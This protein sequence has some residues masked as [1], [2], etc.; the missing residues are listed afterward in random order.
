MNRLFNYLSQRL[1]LNIRLGF[2]DILVL[3]ASYNLLSIQ[4]KSIAEDPGT[5]W[6]IKTGLFILENHSIPSF[7][8][9]LSITRPWVSDQWLGDLIIATIYSLGNWQLL[10]TFFSIVFITTFFIIIR[11]N[12]TSGTRFAIITL[13][14]VVVAFKISQI[15]FLI[16]P[17]A[18]SFTFFTILTLIV[19]SISQKIGKN[20]SLNKYYWK[21]PLLFL[22]W[23][24]I[25]PSFILGLIIVGI[26]PF[27]CLLSPEIKL[28]L[29]LKLWLLFL[30]CTFCT[31]INPFGFALHHSILVLGQS[32][33]FMKLH[34]EWQSPDF[35]NIEGR[36]IEMVGLIIIFSA[37]IIKLPKNYRTFFTIISVT[38]LAHL[39]LKSVRM[40]PY[41]AIYLIPITGQS[42]ERIWFKYRTSKVIRLIPKFNLYE[43]NSSQGLITSIIVIITITV[44]TLGWNKIPLFNDTFGP[45]KKNFPYTEVA[46][47]KDKFGQKDLRMHIYAPPSWGG[48]ITLNL[49]DNLRP[50]I[51]DRNTLIGEEVYKEYLASYSKFSKFQKFIKKYEAS[52]ILVPKDTYL[53]SELKTNQGFAIIYQ[54][55]TAIVA[56]TTR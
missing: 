7:D 54:G 44:S 37:I 51:D 17:V 34:M 41:L 27:S 40:L 33:F 22:L 53:S 46:F 4:L 24:N 38:V 2:Y 42:L 43:R 21:L 8:P 18:F 23:C 6:H 49:P 28:K 47:L 10:Y 20:V 15:H 56:K 3:I 31:F 50:I 35:K 16:R 32:D 30:I 36:L 11:L 52:L 29:Q 39:G 55:K 12:K 1:K 13:F 14:P 45:S 5:G 26:I 48:F 19:H 9:F 25:H